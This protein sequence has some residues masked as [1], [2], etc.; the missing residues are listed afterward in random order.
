MRIFSLRKT[1]ILTA[2]VQWQALIIIPVEECTLEK[3]FLFT[4]K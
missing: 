3:A 1:E 4:K 2:G